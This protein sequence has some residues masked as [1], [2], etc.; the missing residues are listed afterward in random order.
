VKQILAEVCSE[1]DRSIE[2]HG[3]WKEYNPEDML[4]VIH[5]EWNEA[6]IAAMN[7]DLWGEHGVYNELAHVA[8][9]AIKGMLALRNRRETGGNHGSVLSVQ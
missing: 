1:L 6:D 5:R 2:K 9:T 4:E 8:A 3:D 7:D